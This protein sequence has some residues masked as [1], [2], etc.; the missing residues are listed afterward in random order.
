[1]S[2]VDSERPAR[3]A[4]A[5]K[6]WRAVESLEKRAL[7][8]AHI[9]GTPT[10]YSTIQAAVN[11]ASTGATINVD[12]GTYPELVTIGKSL[13]LRGAQAGVDGRLNA[14]RSGVT[15]TIVLGSGTETKVTSPFYINANGL[16]IDGVTSHG[17]PSNPKKGAAIVIA[18]SK[19]GAHI[20]N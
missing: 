11:A 4:A 14:R 9:V 20:Y 3:R 19:S 5:G 18:I 16:T 6:L 1:M 2:V 7:L 13:T 10:V 17:K 8:A 12:A 15:E